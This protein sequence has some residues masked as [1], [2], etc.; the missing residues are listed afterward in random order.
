MS[1]LRNRRLS[2]NH[3]SSVDHVVGSQ[4]TEEATLVLQEALEYI[5]WR[6]HF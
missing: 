4:A 5:L 6:M 3:C 2:V 1:A